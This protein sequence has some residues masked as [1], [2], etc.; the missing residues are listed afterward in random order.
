M[1]AHRS[2]HKS[3][4]QLKRSEAVS[5]GGSS[6]L[7]SSGAASQEAPICSSTRDQLFCCVSNRTGVKSVNTN[8]DTLLQ[9]CKD[10]REG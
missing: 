7:L 10:G 4:D 5:P 1:G 8:R 2:D 3:S 9:R 6:Y